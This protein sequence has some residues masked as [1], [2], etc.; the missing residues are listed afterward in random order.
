MQLLSEMLDD[1][2]GELHEKGVRLLHIGRLEQ[3]D[4][5]PAKRSKMRWNSPAITKPSP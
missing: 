5:L 2:I 1:R 3:L 4:A